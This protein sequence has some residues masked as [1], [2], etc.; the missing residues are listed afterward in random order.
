M[1]ASIMSVKNLL[2][3]N[4]IIPD[5]QRQYKWTKRNI[6]ELL[7]DIS[8]SISDSKK[9]SSDF[10]Y[11]IGS[12]LLY[13]NTET[14]KIEIVDGQQRIISMTLLMKY[15][16]SE[17]TN[18]ILERKFS[19]PLSKRN[20]QANF[21]FIK[22][23]FA[24]KT[25]NEKDEFL[26]AIKNILEVVVI[27]VD[28]L[29]EAFQLFDSQNSRGKSLFPHDLLKAYHLRAM[30]SNLYE[31]EHDVKIW[32][33]KDP[34]AIKEL[35]NDYLF[36]ICNWAQR[37]KTGTFS[38]RDID[39]FKGTDL[40]LNYTF[41]VR[42]FR[43]APYFQINE[44]FIAGHDFFQY[45]EHYLILLKDI[46]RMIDTNPEYS[47]I[48]NV[49]NKKEYNASTGFRYC[50]QL[51]YCTVLAFYD[52]FHTMDKMAVTRLFL[53][54]FMI[55]VDMRHLGMDTINLYATGADKD[56]SNKYA[57]FSVIANARKHTEI[58]N[59]SVI[60]GENGDNWLKLAKELQQ[61]GGI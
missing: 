44:P 43:A 55:R 10:R 39:G 9:Y 53:W 7:Q 41:S 34:K 33:D 6:E 26:S 29:S 12:I 58:S 28:K 45:V 1:A 8:Q 25:S 49:I 42:A 30:D 4:L 16:D 5:Y 3:V 60:C 37:K 13:N 18:S 36:P 46:N 56:Y 27:E 14:G 17:F 21:L 38:D 31:M 22:Q 23:W 40:S 11:R 54:S 35:F 48:L 57:M 2:S 51:F 50:K 15:L 24:L 59:M 20:I 19:D 52:R 47:D 32:E 61:L